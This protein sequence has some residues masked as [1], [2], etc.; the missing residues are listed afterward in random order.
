MFQRKRKN[1]PVTMITA[2]VGVC[3]T[4]IA[5]RKGTT[6]NKVNGEDMGGVRNSG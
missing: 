3:R 6:E 5:A 1:T 4:R 2:V